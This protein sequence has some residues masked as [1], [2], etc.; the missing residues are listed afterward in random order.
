MKA[1]KSKIHGSQCFLGQK[2]TN[3]E[4]I[5]SQREHPARQMPA[6]SPAWCGQAHTWPDCFLLPIS[7]L[8][9]TTR[10]TLHN[11][12]PCLSVPLL[13][14]APCC[15]HSSF[16]MAGAKGCSYYGE[17]LHSDTLMQDPPQLEQTCSFFGSVLRH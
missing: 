8:T 11:R 5:C 16:S 6:W 1:G 7:E 4:L 14:N 3:A 13:C 12:L 15:K 10:L 9:S 2:P 17:C